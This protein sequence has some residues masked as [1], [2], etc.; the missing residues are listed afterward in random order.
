MHWVADER[1]D[2]SVRAVRD[3]FDAM[4]EAEWDRPARSPAE[5]VALEVHRRFLARFVQPGWRIL[6]IGAGPGRF[7]IEMAGL[8]ATVV[9]TDISAVQLGLNHSKVQAAGCEQAVEQRRVLDVRDLSDFADGSFDAVVAYGGP[10]SYAFDEAEAAFTE[11]LRVTRTGG[12]VLASVMSTI[13]SFRYFLAGVA[14]EIKIFG[15]DTVGRVLH[16]GDLRPTQPSGHRCRMFRWRDVA[17]M[18][19]ASPCRLLAASASNAISLGDPGTVGQLADDSRVWPRLLDWEEELAAEPG[20][21]DG[22]THI[23]FAVERT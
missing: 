13:G 12:A 10:L 17:E 6:E 8:G 22:G 3:Y 14:E 19:A 16:T 21:L 4:G 5:Q 18:I 1:A 9:V 15:L 7:T 2:D 11:C 20:M 23:L